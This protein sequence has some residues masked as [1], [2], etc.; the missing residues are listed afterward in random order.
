MF[1]IPEFEM[2][3]TTRTIEGG[4]EGKY[5]FAEN[6]DQQGRLNS[7]RKVRGNRTDDDIKATRRVLR[8]SRSGMGT[9]KEETVGDTG[10]GHLCLSGPG[11]CHTVTCGVSSIG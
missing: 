10:R 7:Q 2:R 4:E 1:G 8:A 5:H 11:G 6:I 3:G 9:R